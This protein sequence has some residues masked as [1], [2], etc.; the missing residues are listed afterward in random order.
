MS[1]P[2]KTVP[3]PYKIPTGQPTPF[4]K[5][6]PKVLE[7]MSMIPDYLKLG[8]SFGPPSQPYGPPGS[9][10]DNVPK[11]QAGIGLGDPK[12]NR[13]LPTNTPQP[14]PTAPTPQAKP[15]GQKKKAKAQAP[16]QPRYIA[17]PKPNPMSVNFDSAEPWL[18][19]MLEHAWNN[20]VQPEWKNE[21]STWPKEA[22]TTYLFY[23]Y[24]G[25]K[26]VLFE[27]RFISGNE[28]AEIIRD[29]MRE[30][31]TKIAEYNQA[32]DA[33]AKQDKLKA[34]QDQQKGLPW[35]PIPRFV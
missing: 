31:E 30:R 11:V 1:L 18:K 12:W 21:I 33:K 22:M 35:R 20:I 5:L 8:G 19:P 13:N 3:K 32:A 17:I 16:K 9:N 4:E 7:R 23:L 27:D 25:K 2:V 26:G 34:L 10:P 24:Q 15:E 29:R 6:P 28:V 14:S